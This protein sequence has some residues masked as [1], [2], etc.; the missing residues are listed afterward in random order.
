MA[1][2]TP[3]L[4]GRPQHV[5]GVAAGGR[6][7]SPPWVGGDKRLVCGDSPLALYLVD[8]MKSGQ[9]GGLEAGQETG[10]LRLFELRVKRVDLIAHRADLEE[11][12]VKSWQYGPA[13][14][15]LEQ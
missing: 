6:A 8:Q 10:C 14:H 12:I 15:C 5:L 9:L 2:Y 11:S 3:A 13:F 1:G 7:Y 4:R